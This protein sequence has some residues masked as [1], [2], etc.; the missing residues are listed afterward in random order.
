LLATYPNPDGDISL[1]KIEG[2]LAG[3]ASIS[4]DSFSWNCL[5]SLNYNGFRVENIIGSVDH[6]SS[7]AGLFYNLNGD[8]VIIGVLTGKDDICTPQ[9]SFYFQ[10]EDFYNYSA[11]AR[12]ILNN[13]LSDDDNF[14]G[15]NDT[16][17][18]AEDLFGTQTCGVGA[19]F[20]ERIVRWEDPDW[21]KIFLPKGCELNFKVYFNHSWGDIDVLALD[22][23]GRLIA[24][25]TTVNDTEEIVWLN[26]AYDQY[27][28]VKVFLVDDTYQG[29][30]MD[31]S[32]SFTDVCE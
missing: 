8:W 28:Y 6:G 23:N 26:D 14:N 20:S 15:D 3:Y 18:T 11:E 9:N 13:G 21:Y 31:V 30:N 19:S 2:A 25:S 29:Y 10:F 1:L 22:S 32:T 7:G 24:Q 4:S 17:S 16:K 12:R 27:V 5:F